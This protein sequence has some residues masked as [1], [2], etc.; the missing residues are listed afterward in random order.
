MTFTIFINLR[1]VTRQWDCKV[2]TPHDK[3]D[4]MET[5]NS[6]FDKSI[7]NVGNLK[8]VQNVLG[9]AVFFVWYLK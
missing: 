7:R 8:H 6:H 1:V 3:L 2:F 5:L 9:G 4:L